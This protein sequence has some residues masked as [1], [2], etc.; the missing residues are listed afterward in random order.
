MR[1][2]GRIGADQEDGSSGDS[3]SHARARADQGGSG[4]RLVRRLALPWGGR[5]L[6]QEA[7]PETRPPMRGRGRIRADKAD[8]EDGSSGDSPSRGVAEV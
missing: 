5:G 4:R 7:R 6:I 2:R 1:G 3:P 8:Q